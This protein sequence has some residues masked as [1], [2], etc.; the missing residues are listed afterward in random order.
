MVTADN[1]KASS[2][3]SLDRREVVATLLHERGDL[4]VVTGLGSSTYDV[5]ACGES[6]NNF[7]L[8]GA[9][10]LSLIHI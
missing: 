1:S 2:E 5:A 7:Y 8:W 10:G 3:P 6:D 9:M 4:L